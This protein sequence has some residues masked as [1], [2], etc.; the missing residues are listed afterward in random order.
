[1]F[2]EVKHP[3]RVLM[4][5]YMSPTQ[6]AVDLMSDGKTDPAIFDFLREQLPNFGVHPFL[7]HQESTGFIFNR[8]SAAI[9]RESLAVVAEGV[10]TPED[11]DEMFKINVGAPAGP[12]ALM[13]EGGLDG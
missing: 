7:A 6:N 2:D 8:I 13:D 11:V 9:K 10:S 4:H 1:M 12:F 5:F 3:E